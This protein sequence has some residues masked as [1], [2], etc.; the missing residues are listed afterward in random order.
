[1]S[2]TQEGKNRRTRKSYTPTETEAIKRG[3][4][5]FG[6]GRWKEIKV[7][8]MAILKNGTTVQ[9]KDHYRTMILRKE[10][11]PEKTDK[12]KRRPWIPAE[13]EAVLRGVQKY[14]KGAWSIIKDE[15]PLILKNRT[16]MQIKDYSRT[17]EFNRC[18]SRI[19]DFDMGEVCPP[20]RCPPTVEFLESIVLEGSTITGDLENIVL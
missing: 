15:Y 14:G 13:K 2:N 10:V 7:A 6:F 9:I 19:G 1:M 11:F 8:Y 17:T 4:D 3:V 18:A 16:C 5:E 20:C 12:P